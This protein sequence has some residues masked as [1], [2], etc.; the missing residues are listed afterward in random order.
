MNLPEN[1]I[2][3]K[4]LLSPCRAVLSIQTCEHQRADLVL[5]AALEGASHNKD[6]AQG[7]K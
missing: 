4:S 3:T 6:N 1:N 5:M 7:L 2:P